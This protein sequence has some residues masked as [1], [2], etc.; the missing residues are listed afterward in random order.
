[1]FLPSPCRLSRP[2]RKVG[3]VDNWDDPLW[4]ALTLGIE[5]IEDDHNILWEKEPDYEGGLNAKELNKL[6]TSRGIGPI[7][8]QTPKGD[9]SYNDAR[10]LIVHRP[11][12][13]PLKLCYWSR[14]AG[15]EVTASRAERVIKALRAWRN[16]S[17]GSVAQLR[18][19][20]QSTPPL[21]KEN[22]QWVRNKRAATLD[23][24]KTRTLADY[25]HDGIALSD[26]TFG[27]DRDGRLWRRQG[28]RN[29]H[30]W[31]LK[32]SLLNQ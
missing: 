9:P 6:A 7:I 25:R 28:T 2:A 12:G 16:L 10:Y 14:V 31:Y 5:A 1:M 27:R 32:S 20:E 11:A 29:S 3:I 23:G 24:L 15:H 19:L 13:P 8:T 18:E 21:N 22:G 4:A 30:P 17:D 26:G